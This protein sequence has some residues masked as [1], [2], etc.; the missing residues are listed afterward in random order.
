VSDCPPKPNPVDE[1]PIIVVGCPRSGTTMLQLMLHAHPRIAIPPETR[2]LLP[3]YQQRRSF[4]DLELPDRRRALARWIVDRPQ[5]R[6]ADL[7]LDPDDIVE[8]IVAAPPTLG[9]ALGVILRS[10]SARFGKPRWGDK[11]PAYLQNLDLILRLFPT[12]QIVNIVRDGRDCVAS[13]T[14]M[15]WHRQDIYATI[16][17]WA[18]AVDDGRRAAA[19]LR[20]DQYHQLRYE[21]LVAD[22]HTHLAAL[23]A[24]LGEDYDPAMARPSAVA[25]VAVPARKTWHARTHTDVDTQRVHSWRQRLTAD[26]IALC[27]AALGERLTHHGYHL[28]GAPAPTRSALLR[29]RRAAAHHRMAPAWRTLK[30][31]ADRMI[32]QLPVAAVP[33]L[34]GAPGGGAV[35]AAQRLP[36]APPVTDMS[37][38]EASADAD[39]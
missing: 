19:R 14:E 12:A 8:Q 11:R 2:F 37:P 34:P 28:T 20:S 26:E 15:S 3:V 7:G 5:T 1:R 13:L 24:F 31:T 25:D 16:A 29:Y 6:F 27:E 32:P 17:A 18:R 33:A 10:Y 38:A 22:P 4:G 9:S 23:C 35:V 36:A 30:H 21:D 39:H